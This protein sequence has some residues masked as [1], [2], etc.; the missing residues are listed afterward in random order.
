MNNLSVVLDTTY[1]LPLFGIEPS[2]GNKFIGEIQ[3]MWENQLH[4]FKFFLPDVCL[5]EVLHKL[6]REF[7]KKNDPKIME[8][9][10]LVLPSIQTSESVELIESFKN[11]TISEYAI[12][13]RGTGHPDLF[14]C[15]IG[16]SAIYTE[17]ILVTE[18][19]PLKDK[20]LS[21]SLE[22][23]IKILDWK[24]FSKFKDQI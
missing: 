24:K 3:K 22:K 7:R 21:L 17:S 4:D 19:Q 12:K 2:L 13:I 16:A 5:I 9:Y 10:S 20:I 15:L 14:D 23:D 6:N 18:D 1:V 8:R 11:Q